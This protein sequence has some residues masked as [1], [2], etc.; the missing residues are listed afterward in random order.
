MVMTTAFESISDATLRLRLLQSILASSHR[1]IL[2][3]RRFAR[4]CFFR[5]VGHLSQL[6]DVTIDLKTIAHH[7]EGQ[8]FIISN[9][10]DYGELAAT[11]G[12]L[13]IAIDSGD[14]PSSSYAPEEKAFNRDVDSLA[15]KIKTM[16]TDINDTGGSHIGRTEAKEVLEVFQHW[17]SYGVRTKPPP[18]QCLFGDSTL[19]GTADRHMMEAFVDRGKQDTA[20]ALPDSMKGRG[21]QKVVAAS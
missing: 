15:L 1:L 7:L 14:L 11:I 9:V 16:F 13:S 8:Q 18:K 2:L 4:A 20:L 12:I 10:T 19:E 17:L 21:E 6:G 3:R 5:D